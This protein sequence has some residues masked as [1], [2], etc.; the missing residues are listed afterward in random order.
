MD[1]RLNIGFDAKRAFLNDAGLGHFSRNTILSLSGFYPENNYFLFTPSEEPDRFLAPENSTI[2]HPTNAWWRM[3]KPWWRTYKITSLAQAAELDI[4]HGLSNELPHGIEQ[5]DIKR[6]VTIHDLIFMRFPE[7]YKTADR[8]IYLRKVKHACQAADKIIAISEQTKQDLIQFIGANPAKIK[9]IYQAINPIYFKKASAEDLQDT[10][11]RLAL[12]P[13]FMLT[14]GTLEARK[15]LGSILKA[16]DKLKS[17]TP[18]VVIGKK[19]NYLHHLKPLI[20]K[21]GD[22][23]IFLHEVDDAD[24]SRL[25]QLAKLTIYPSVFEGFGL[26]IAEAQACGCPVITSNISSMPEAG[27]DGAHYIQP[28]KPKEI[29]QAIQ[30][31]S[32]DV[33]YR[34]IL[35]LKG[36]LNAERFTTKAYAQ[37]LMTLYN[38]LHHA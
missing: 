13:H 7:F 29:S 20:Q 23:L 12:P 2:I 4:Y 1:Y 36:Q 37:Q 32:E 17:N 35:I 14:V 34:D 24:L 6:V 21:L 10:Q 19:T 9:V 16:I 38:K 26:P 25:Y 33:N 11:K 3:V 31:I 5:T 22:Q 27:G 8:K 30:Q 18:L 28:K 15:N